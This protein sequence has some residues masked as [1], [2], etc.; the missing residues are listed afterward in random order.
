M[1]KACCPGS[2]DPI[3]RGHI[4]I[5]ERAAGVFDEVIVA[6]S[7]GSSNPSKRAMFTTEERMELISEVTTHI[8]GLKIATFNGL[9]VD[10]C[11][12]QGAN[13]V[14]KGLRAVTDF[15]YEM[16]MAQ[17]NARMGVETMFVA[18]SPKFSYLSSSLMKE[19]IALGGDI[20]GLVPEVVE[21]R[22]KERLGK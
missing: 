16:Q 9:L 22:L 12:E 15:D 4:D 11:R 17:M 14:V 6:V 19:V 10:F 2:F 13:V 7:E 5:I 8:D 3:T 21:Q 1:T 18:T 20:S